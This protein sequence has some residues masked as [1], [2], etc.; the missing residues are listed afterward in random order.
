VEETIR[1]DAKDSLDS[2]LSVISIQR[3]GT[4]P[5]GTEP[6]FLVAGPTIAA[7]RHVCVGIAPLTVASWW[8]GTIGT[9]SGVE[10]NKK[11]DSLII[12]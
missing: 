4:A 11:I 10:P 12:S 9:P 7:D 1:F 8:H 6:S 2:G 3:H 5:F